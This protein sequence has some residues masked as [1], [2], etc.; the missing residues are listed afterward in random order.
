MSVFRLPGGHPEKQRRTCIPIMKK[1]AHATE[2]SGTVV[3]GVTS[4]LK[5]PQPSTVPPA[6]RTSP[7]ETENSAIGAEAVKVDRQKRRLDRQ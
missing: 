4:H 2:E 3:G 5:H 7:R 6:P 1:A